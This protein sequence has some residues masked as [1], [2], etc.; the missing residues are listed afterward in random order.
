MWTWTGKCLWRTQN[1]SEESTL[2]SPLVPLLATLA[3]VTGVVVVPCNA[4]LQ[5][6]PGETYS[7]TNPE[8]P[9][10]FTGPLVCTYKL[11]PPVGYRAR[12]LCPEM[13]VGLSELVTCA[14]NNIKAGTNTSKC[15][16]Q[17]IAM[18]SPT[19]LDLVFNFQTGSGKYK[20]DVTLSADP[21]QCGRFNDVR[22]SFTFW[23]QILISFLSSTFRI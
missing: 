9:N 13:D 2:I 6:S 3:S 10:T 7:L 15:P 8:Y 12:M 14:D 1:I 18:N 19:V 16:L 4:T 20:C 17:N 21:C 22:I 5:L 23:S 11:T